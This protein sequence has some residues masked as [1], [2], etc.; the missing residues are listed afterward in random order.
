MIKAFKDVHVQP[1]M[2]DLLFY[3]LG[4]F[5]FFNSYLLAVAASICIVAL[6]RRL[7]RYQKSTRG[8]SL[9]AF[10]AYLNMLHSH[11]TV[12]SSFKNAILKTERYDAI[13]KMVALNASDHQL[14]DA[15]YE[16]FTLP[17]VQRFIDMLRLSLHSNA[18]ASKIVGATLD[19]LYKENKTLE[20][21][22]LILYQKRVEHMV[23]SIAPLAII[24]MIKLSTPSYL[25]IMYT[26]S[27]GM[28]IMLGAFGLLITMR[29]I[30]ERI[31][32][33]KW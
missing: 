22:R 11:L 15:I 21:A 31:I 25:D 24:L 26:T 13:T 29:L 19:Q 9:K 7:K 23:L 1:L 28:F 10:E 20:E 18:H 17:E 8:L 12:G 5:C 16:T 6:S 3:A 2:N 33:I 32:D 14:F 30:G 4:M 27:M